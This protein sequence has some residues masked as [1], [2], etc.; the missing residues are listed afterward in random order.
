M[1]YSFK[2]AAFLIA[3]AQISCVSSFVR[4]G[5]LDLDGYNFAFLA[6]FCGN[7][8]GPAVQY[9]FS[10]PKINCCISFLSYFED[11]WWKI[12][13]RPELDCNEKVNS[14][15]PNGS[16]VVNLTTNNSRAG[17]HLVPSETNSLVMSCRGYLMYEVSTE[18]PSTRKCWYLAVSNCYS[19][20]KELKLDY[21]LN[22]TGAAPNKATATFHRLSLLCDLLLNC[23][24]T[25]WV[26]CTSTAH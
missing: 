4:E 14:L 19:A 7:Y 23:F 6:S 13:P 1:I 2:F 12:W 5:H 22:I 21:S 25:M 16:Q 11:Q 3:F 20:K 18:E 17:C 9:N 10:Y 15:D 24:L 8:T 26:S